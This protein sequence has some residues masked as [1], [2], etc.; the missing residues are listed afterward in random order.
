MIQCDRAWG[1]NTQVGIGG[2]LLESNETEHVGGSLR[3]RK[4]GRLMESN[5]TVRQ[6]V[7]VE[8]LGW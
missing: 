1:W 5:D 2:T 6:G 3:S 7:W 4:T 8:H